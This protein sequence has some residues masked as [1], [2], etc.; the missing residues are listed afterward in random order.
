MSLIQEGNIGDNDHSSSEHT[1]RRVPPILDDL[2]HE[3]TRLGPL[4]L[5]IRN[6]K[7]GDYLADTIKFKETDNDLV[8]SDRAIVLESMRHRLE[9]Q[10]PSHTVEQIVDQQSQYPL[11]QRTGTP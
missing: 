1:D 11:I 5:D 4:L 9:D 10:F 2:L 3:N 7:F 8:Q 6:R